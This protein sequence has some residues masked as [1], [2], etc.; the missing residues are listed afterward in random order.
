VAARLA[1]V[2]E[3]DELLVGAATRERLGG[4]F[5]FET[6]GERTLRNVEA[7]VRVFRL[8]LP[9]TAPAVPA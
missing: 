1:A 8:A 5:P 9:E 3:G 6:L 4:E 2:T 7:P